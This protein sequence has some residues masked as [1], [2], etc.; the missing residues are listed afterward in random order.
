MPDHT[1]EVVFDE[2]SGKPAGFAAQSRQIPV[3]TGFYDLDGQ[4]M[5]TNP[6]EIG[7]AG[8]LMWYG[9]LRN[10]TVQRMSDGE[11][12]A[13]GVKNVVV[14]VDQV[15][16]LPSYK[17]SSIVLLDSRTG[18]TTLEAARGFR[19]ARIF[20]EN[21]TRAD[22]MSV[23]APDGNL[24]NLIDHTGKVLLDEFQYEIYEVQQD[25][26]IVRAYENGQYVRHVI[27]LDTQQI[28]YRADHETYMRLLPESLLIEKENAL[29][30]IDYQDQ[31]LYDTP[32]ESFTFFDWEQDGDPEYVVATVL[33][34]NAYCTVLLKPD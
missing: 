3:Y 9:D 28:L 11:I 32:I 5:L 18:E 23:T 6:I 10:F 24:Q 2:V 27:D 34:S 16:L 7:C 26:A 15:A 12:L 1:L 29:Y 33:R 8:D 14:M 20:S 30:L 21:G 25:R 17:Y 4:R 19:P 13:E 22:Y 31:L